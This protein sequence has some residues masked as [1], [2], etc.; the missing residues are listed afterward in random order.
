MWLNLPEAEFRKAFR[1]YLDELK[2]NIVLH[3]LELLARG[4]DVALVCYE[5]PGEF[6]H[7]RIVAEWLKETA[8]ITV[9]EYEPQDKKTFNQLSL[10]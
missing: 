7:R 5:K 10:F 6:C 8:G 9:E 4:N 1:S 3:Q 2:V